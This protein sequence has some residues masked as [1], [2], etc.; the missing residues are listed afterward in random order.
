MFHFATP[1]VARFSWDEDAAVCSVV[2]VGARVGVDELN[3][4]GFPLVLFVV[5]ASMIARSRLSLWIS[6]GMWVV[7]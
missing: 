7:L 2:V 5:S 4:M 3:I 6:G 1:F